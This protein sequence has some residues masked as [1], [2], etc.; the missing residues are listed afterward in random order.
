MTRD[1]SFLY[2]RKVSLS[3]YIKK[4]TCKIIQVGKVYKALN[5]STDLR[6]PTMSLMLPLETE[7]PGILILS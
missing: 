5:G 6:S 1:G 2:D 4:P 7:N 3:Y